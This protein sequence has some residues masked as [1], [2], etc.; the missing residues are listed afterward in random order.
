[1]GVVPI[2]LCLISG[3]AWADFVFGEPEKVPG[4]NS[5][6]YD[7]SLTISAD[8]LEMYF[9]SRRPPGGG[10]CGFNIWVSRRLTTAEPWGAPEMLEPPMNSPGPHSYLCLSADGL[11]LYFTDGDPVTGC[12]PQHGGHGG[13]DLMVSKRASRDDPWGEPENL[14]PVVNTRNNEGN[15]SISADGLS[16]YFSSDRPGGQGQW[17]LWVTR[18][19][20]IGEAWGEAA[21]LGSQINVGSWSWETTPFISPDGLSLYFAAG[22]YTTDI[23]VSTRP[24]TSSPWGPRERFSP[25]NSRRSEYWLTFAKG[26]SVLYFVRGDDIYLHQLPNPP[27][28]KAYDIW[29]VE[30]SPIVDFNADGLVD[31]AD[32]DLMVLCWGTDVSLCDIAPMPSGDGVVDVNDLIV[33]V[34]H[35]VDARAESDDVSGAQ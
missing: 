9:L 32:I 3:P 16:L 21:N 20:A 24:T 11:E 34:E 25:V 29:Q 26:C 15:S 5:S 6:F 13:T 28:L 4:I 30:V 18:R 19:D 7:G 14:G 22:D 35:I 1:M 31:S 10:T 17:D 2:V 23:Y 12:L 33:L 27:G 8:G